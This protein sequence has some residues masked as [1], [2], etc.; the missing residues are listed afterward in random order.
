MKKYGLILIPLTLFLNSCTLPVILAGAAVGL[1]GTVYYDKRSAQTMLEDHHITSNVGKKINTN[2]GLSKHIAVSVNTY[3]GIVLLTGQAQTPQF[4]SQLESITKSVVGVRKIYNEVDI[5][6]P[7]AHLQNVTDSWLTTK[8]K[9]E[10]FSKQGFKSNELKIVTTNGSVYIM[11]KVNRAEG[12]K[13]ANIVRRVSGVNRV[14][15]VFEYST[16]S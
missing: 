4:R 12:D 5:A 6:A 9:S 11:G 3:D 1:G 2:K 7:D 16:Y 14:I 15:K 13:V 8:V 10:L